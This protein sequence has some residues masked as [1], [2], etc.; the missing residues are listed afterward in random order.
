MSYEETT[1]KND[2]S[3]ALHPLSQFT[4]ERLRHGQV[5]GYLLLDD[6]GDLLLRGLVQRVGLRQLLR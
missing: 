6:S 4:L 3:T 1:K 2:V 5:L